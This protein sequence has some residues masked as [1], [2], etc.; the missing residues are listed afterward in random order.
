MKEWNLNT[1]ELRAHAKE[2]KVGDMVNLSGTI[3][4]ARDAAHKRL[5]AMLDEGKDLPFDVKDAVIYYAGPTQAKPGEVIGSIGP[6]TSGRMD[7]YAPRLLD[8]GLVAMI[9]KGGRAKPVVDAIVRNGAVYF[10]A[11]G[12]AGAVMA[13]C[14][15]EAEVVCYDDLGSEAVRRLVVENMPLTVIIDS[16]G[17]NLYTDGPAQYLAA[18]T[19]EETGL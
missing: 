14:V 7:P 18:C 13:S 10:C 4:T 8:M 16:E 3:Y 5:F 6:T 9:G 1:A 19:E 2:I 11:I 12:G 15:K 17:R